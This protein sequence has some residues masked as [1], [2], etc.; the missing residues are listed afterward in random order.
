MLPT[1]A[2]TPFDTNTQIFSNTPAVEIPAKLNALGKASADFYNQTGEKIT[3]Y[4]QEV[5]T[6]ML[7]NIS[8][9]ITDSG[10]GY[11]ISQVNDMSFAGDTLTELDS[12]DRIVRLRQGTTELTAIT[13]GEDGYIDAFTEK[14]NIGGTTT[15]K[16]YTVAY[17][18]DNKITITE[19]I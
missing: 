10:A 18:D 17:T 4:T 19:V 8:E 9:Y 11:S 12:E 2:F 15:T 3:N 6:N 16:S 1:L 5:V 14:I 13:Y 7:T